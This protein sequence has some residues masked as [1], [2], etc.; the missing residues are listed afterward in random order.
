MIWIIAI[1]LCCCSCAKVDHSQPGVQHTPVTSKDDSLFLSDDFEELGW[2]QYSYEKYDSGLVLFDSSL[3]F[4][5]ENSQAWHGRALMLDNLK[6]DDE[7]EIAYR[8]AEKY[9]STN[10]QAIWHCG[11]MLARAGKKEQALRQ[12]R[13]VIALDS[14]YARAVRNEDCWT[15]LWHDTDFLEVVGFLEPE[16]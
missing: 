10:R 12:L 2:D 16:K 11:C 8:N 3:K 1:A 15:T 7:A 14:S 13:T 5:P 6:R 9:D 4:N